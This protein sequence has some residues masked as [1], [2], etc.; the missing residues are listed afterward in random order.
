QAVDRAGDGQG[1]QRH[2]IRGVP[3]AQLARA[4][5]QRDDLPAA[6]EGD[7]ASG[8]G[9]EVEPE[10]FAGVEAVEVVPLPAA[11]VGAAEAGEGGPRATAWRRRWSWLW[12]SWLW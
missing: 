9:A 7:T 10:Q 12:V 3:E 2:A 6:D 4:L 1:R 5:G 11:A 8:P